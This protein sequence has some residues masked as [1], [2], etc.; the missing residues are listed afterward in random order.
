MNKAIEAARPINE[1]LDLTFK[2]SK[3]ILFGFHITVSETGSDV[4]IVCV[5]TPIKLPGESRKDFMDRDVAYAG[6]LVIP[7]TMMGIRG[8]Q[9]LAIKHIQKTSPY[10]SVAGQMALDSLNDKGET[11]K[12][13]FECL[14]EN[15]NK[16]A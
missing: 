8:C 5:T 16:I 7:P 14:N 15:F 2:V 6:L 3:L 13:I 9:N 10:F 12:I 11:S 1:D 4:E